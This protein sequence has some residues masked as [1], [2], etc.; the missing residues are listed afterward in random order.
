MSGNRSLVS[1]GGPIFTM[2]D[3]G[4]GKVAIANIGTINGIEIGDLK[5]NRTI[6]SNE[7][8]P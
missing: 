5:G 8:N 7:H 3:L 4:D 1:A 2:R 6:L